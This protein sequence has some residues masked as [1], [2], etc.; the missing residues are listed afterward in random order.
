[1]IFQQTLFSLLTLF[2]IID[3][4]E[5]MTLIIVYLVRKPEICLLVLFVCYVE[6]SKTLVPLAMF[7]I[8]YW[9]ALW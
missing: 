3:I 5:A 2:G 8:H 6:T 1:M 9:K 7:L 4:V